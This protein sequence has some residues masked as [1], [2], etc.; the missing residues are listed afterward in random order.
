VNKKIYFFPLSVIIE[1]GR[2]ISHYLLQLKTF[3]LK[4]EISRRPAGLV[5]SI[6]AKAF[7][8]GKM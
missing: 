5:K 2:L 1:P 6:T 4:P 3:F 7:L 8:E